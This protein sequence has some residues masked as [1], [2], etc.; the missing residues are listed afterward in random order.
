MKLKKNKFIILYIVSILLLV[1]ILIVSVPITK[2]SKKIILKNNQFVTNQ[3][4]INS[5]AKSSKIINRTMNIRLN[6]VVDNALPW[7]FQVLQNV[8]ELKVGQNTIVKYE[9][10]NIS[11]K[12]ITA[13]A[14]FIVDPKKI[15]PYIIK[16]ECF[17]FI[18]Q[19]LAPGESQIFTMVFFLD[20]SLDSDKDLDNIKDL[21]FTYRFS[22]YTS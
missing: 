17:C 5:K 4:I 19:T 20:S 9:G 2:Y 14:D 3:V 1:I 12:T 8:I 7:D 18:E 21:V 22:E 15:T 13:T 6:A 10:K 11:N 16:T